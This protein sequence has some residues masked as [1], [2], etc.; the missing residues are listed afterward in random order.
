[1]VPKSGARGLK[2]KEPGAAQEHSS[3]EGPNTSKECTQ[4]SL[5]EWYVEHCKCKPI[6]A[7]FGKQSAIQQYVCVACLSDLQ[8]RQSGLRGYV[9]DRL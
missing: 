4:R 6:A 3:E 9:G 5:R 1:V 2:Q 7:C 8:G